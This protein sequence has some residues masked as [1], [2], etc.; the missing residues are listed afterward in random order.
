MR[1]WLHLKP[2]RAIVTIQSNGW[3]EVEEAMDQLEAMVARECGGSAEWAVADK[4]RP[5]V[6]LA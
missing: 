2:R 6:T 5:I 3:G 4:G 1:L